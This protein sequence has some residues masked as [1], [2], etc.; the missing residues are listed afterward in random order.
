MIDVTPNANSNILECRV[1]GTLTGA[2]LDH[3]VPVLKKH[4]AEA[5]D[6]RLLLI[7]DDFSGWSDIATFWKDLKLDA[8][9]IGEFNRIALV[10]NARWEE[11]LTK[12]VDPL[13]PNEI[14][15]FE[16]HAMAHARRWVQQERQQQ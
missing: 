14:E 4:I 10:G 7:M 8:E 1:S 9:Y 6:P 15:F 11:W 2:D 3:M 12:L 16:P 5:G 13:T